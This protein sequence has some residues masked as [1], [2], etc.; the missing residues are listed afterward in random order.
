VPDGILLNVTG[1]QACACA[2]PTERTKHSTKR[3][4]FTFIFIFYPLTQFS[5][6]IYMDNNIK[7]TISSSEKSLIDNFTIKFKT[8]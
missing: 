5:T 2:N 4:D 3:K 8:N 1:L 6:H 7:T